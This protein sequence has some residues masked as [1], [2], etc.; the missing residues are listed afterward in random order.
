MPRG[1]ICGGYIKLRRFVRRRPWC[2]WIE[3][4]AGRPALPAVLATVLSTTRGV[5]SAGAETL[6]EDFGAIRAR[7]VVLR[8]LQIHFC[9][10][11]PGQLKPVQK[12]TFRGPCECNPFDFHQTGNLGVCMADVFD[13]ST[14]C[15]VSLESRCADKQPSKFFP[16]FHWSLAACAPRASRPP[17]SSNSL[18]EGQQ[19]G[20]V[21]VEMHGLWNF[22]STYTECRN[23]CSLAERCK[24]MYTHYDNELQLCHLSTRPFYPASYTHVH[25][26]AQPRHTHLIQDEDVERLW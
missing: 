6:L 3:D 24:S 5:A 25:S 11:L 8:Q 9:L 13:D 23:Y 16:S 14:F 12:V 19:E 4:Q 17:T 2:L 26:V 21:V 22:T 18:V 15:Y 7:R 10:S 1:T 20:G